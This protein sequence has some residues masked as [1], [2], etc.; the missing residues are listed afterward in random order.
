MHLFTKLAQKNPETK[1]FNISGD[2]D[3]N[4]DGLR[5]LNSLGV[6]KGFLRTEAP[7]GLMILSCS[8]RCRDI[9]TVCLKFVK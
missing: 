1:Y 2:F 5:R 8:G 9:K 6:H 3:L 7:K 4:C